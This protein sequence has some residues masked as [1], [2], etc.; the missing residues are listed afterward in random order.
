[1]RV[2]DLC[3]IDRYICRARVALSLLALISM[4]VDPVI[5]GGPFSI[6]S[7]LLVI[8]TLHLAFS[9]V[10]LRYVAR[11]DTA[12]R[13]AFVLAA[14]DLLFAAMVA[15]VTEGATSP[16]YVFFCFAIIA[17]GCRKGLRATLQ[18]T[19]A[20]MLLYL[21]VILLFHES[22]GHL[23]V[24]RPAYLGLIGC[25]AGFLGQERVD[26]E[27][28][29]ADLEAAAERRSIARSL[30]DGHVQALAASNL[31]LE[32]CRELLRRGDVAEAH[33]EL[34]GLQASVTR[35]YDAVRSYIRTLASVA[36]DSPAAGAQPPRETIVAVRADFTA[37]GP[38]AE[39]I[40]QILLEGLRNIIRHG[41][42]RS[43]SLRTQ[44]DRGA[45]RIQ[46]DDDGIGFP[47]L[48]PPPWSITSRVAELGGSVSI[49]P[50]DVKGAH[51]E[52]ELP[53]PE[54]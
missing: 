3:G 5:G 39:E 41:G 32:A 4:Y 38:L 2:Q 6:D 51:L 13:S 23:Y 19:A 29:V 33:R 22:S 35:E 34:T 1:V 25:L 14:C 45:I 24:M 16:S 28:R 48:A 52:I 9:A 17:I 15:A 31:R 11:F 30:H 37:A 53:S 26:F 46:L 47:P 43:A 42:A 18:V 20:S 54:S 40:L 44:A 50:G 10:T 36:E 8:L 12:G 7:P 27:S 21:G 49:D